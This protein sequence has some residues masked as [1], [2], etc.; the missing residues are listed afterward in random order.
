MKVVFSTDQVYLHG[1]IE[2]VIATKANYFADVFGYEVVILTTEQNGKKPC[3]HLSEKVRIVDIAVNYN[4]SKSYFHPSNIS[5]I[6]SHLSAWKKFMKSEKPDFLISCNYSFDYYWLPFL[7]RKTKKLKEFHSSGYAGYMLRQG[8][9]FKSRMKYAINDYIN[10]K[11]DRIVLLNPSETKFYPTENTVVIPN[12][13]SPSDLAAT[14][15]GLRAIAAGRI[16]PVK[17]FDE[18]IEIWRIVIEKVPDFQLDIFGSGDQTDIAALQNLVRK[19][20]LGRVVR[21]NPATSQLQQEMLKS[22]LYV[23][24]SESECFPMV[25]LE[26]LAVGLP[27]VSYDCP[28]G[29]KHIVT[30]GD[31][32]YLLPQHDREAFAEKIVSL[33]TNRESLKALGSAARHNSMRFS[34]ETVMPLWVKLFDKLSKET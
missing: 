5:R 27:I 18:L 23:M 3:Y 34:H 10:S 20:G 9:S 26:S 4:R 15:Q 8:K 12:S 19:H 1:G 7:H 31:D 2:K 13:I 16:A 21:I 25:L 29:P 11:F 32:G 24:T 6:S 14:F 30:D 22:S 33:A 17:N 28:T